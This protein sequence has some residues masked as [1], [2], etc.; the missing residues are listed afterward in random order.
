MK[1]P[2]LITVLIKM[3]LSPGSLNDSTL[4]YDRETQKFVQDLFVVLMLVTVPW[5]LIP[6]P[7]LLQRKYYQDL[8]IEYHDGNDDEQEKIINSNNAIIS[9]T[10]PYETEEKTD[11]I[12]SQ[13]ISTGNI[14]K[15]DEEEGFDMAE[16]CIHQLIH[17]IEYVLGTVSNTAS[18]LR[19]WALS[20]AHAELSQVFYDKTIQSSLG[21]TGAF[22]ILETVITCYLFIALTSGVLLSMDV[23]EC[24]L[25]ALRLHWV[26][27]QSKFYYADGVPFDPFSYS[28]SLKAY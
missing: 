23:L 20:L 21:G 18:Y 16:V 28:S 6:K 27:F 5:M 17:T 22:S 15:G 26:E 2:S 11:L 1:T 10:L 14:K 4:L 19:L 3:V 7:F 13:N 8:Q 25:H 9:S 24:F 12:K